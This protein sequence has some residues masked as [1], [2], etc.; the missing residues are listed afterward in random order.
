MGAL[1]LRLRRSKA[2]K[3]TIHRPCHLHG[4]WRPRSLTDIRGPVFPDEY[5][6]FLSLDAESIDHVLD[7]YSSKLGDVVFLGEGDELQAYVAAPNGSELVK[8]GQEW[9]SP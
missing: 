5:Q 4:S 9:R 2:V 1:T 3:A 7:Q 6:E 8:F